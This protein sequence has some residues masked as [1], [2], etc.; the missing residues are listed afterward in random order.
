MDARRPDEG[1]IPIL[2]RVGLG[3]VW[4]YEG[5]VGKL[6][7]SSPELLGLIARWQPFPGEPSAFLKAAGVFEILLGLLLI[8]GWMVRSAAAVQCGL[9]L[10]F[11]AGLAVV[12]PET[13]VNPA[14]PVSKNIGLFAAGLCLV[15]LGSG[16]DA[17]AQ[18]SWKDRAVPLILRLGLAFVWL[19]EG[20]I[21]KW[22]FPGPGEVEIVAR[23]GLVH[24]HIPLFLKLLGA[25]EA[26][27]GFTILAGL[28]VRRLAVLQVGL[29]T[30]FTAIVGWT[31]PGSLV[32]PLGGLAKNLGLLGGV[33]ALYH[34]GSGPFALDGWLARN[35]AWRR[36]QL[37]ASLQGNRLVE[38]AAVEVY[39][40]QAQAA[41]DGNT[42]G[43]LE[44]LA[45]DEDHHAADLASLIRR[46]GG[47]PIPLAG[48]C[49]GVAWVLG[50]LGV[51]L[52]M[53]ASLH[54]DLWMEERG[55]S[56]YASSAR[57]L[58]AEDGITARALMGMQNQEAQHIR[59][60]RDHLR[61]MQP[62]A[63]RPRR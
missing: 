18:G 30:A 17:T 38:I 43:L 52:G 60:L 46:H 34:A 35:A 54:F 22:L 24:F 20:I 3:A 57:L 36:W 5:L 55:G 26:A 9:L 21:P 27:L 8:R 33:L 16:R 51:I 25:A 42:H 56:L 59:L 29:L 61:A 48:L 31:S 47:R 49:R 12:M 28:W 11:S 2:L 44:K 62:P 58:P 41:T 7:V 14:G 50:C 37:M 13:L 6:L 23:T 19:Y 10:L 15:L 53:R 39:Q 4:L 1:Q 40:V 45:L 63:S 32:N